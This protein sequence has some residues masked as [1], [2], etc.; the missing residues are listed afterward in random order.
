VS[1][2]LS[3]E[4]FR[5]Y[6]RATK[7]HISQETQGLEL[8]YEKTFEVAKNNAQNTT[9]FVLGPFEKSFI[10]AGASSKEYTKEHYYYSKSRRVVQSGLQ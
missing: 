8:H 1:K 9:R 4:G 5:T 2:H 7:L 10:T 3:L 6:K